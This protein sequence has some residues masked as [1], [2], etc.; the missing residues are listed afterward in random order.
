MKWGL[1]YNAWRCI[2]L[3]TGWALPG[4]VRSVIAVNYKES[5]AVTVRAENELVRK[6]S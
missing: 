2:R 1:G 4:R 5:K 6:R 3:E